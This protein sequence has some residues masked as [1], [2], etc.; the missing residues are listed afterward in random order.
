[1]INA[2]CQTTPPESIYD[3]AAHTNADAP[4][5]KAD[6]I[7]NSFENYLPQRSGNPVRTAGVGASHPD[8]TLS[9]DPSGVP[10]TSSWP[11][12]SN[13]LSSSSSIGLSSCNSLSATLADTM[14]ADLYCSTSTCEGKQEH[15]S[16]PQRLEPVGGDMPPSCHN[17]TLP[18]TITSKSP[19][20]RMSRSAGNSP[21]VFRRQQSAGAGMGRIADMTLT[22]YGFLDC[23]LVANLENATVVGL[24]EDQLREIAA[25]KPD[26]INARVRRQ[27]RI[28][29]L[30]HSDCFRHRSSFS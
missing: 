15:E 25:S 1:M 29:Q 8:V 2:G 11:A 12:D 23:D 27:N 17:I 18:A 9:D 7:E 21:S 30:R 13:H 16:L 6:E 10:T 14:L 22:Q 19:G 24:S 4:G 28:K 5:S 20:M 26:R 3:I